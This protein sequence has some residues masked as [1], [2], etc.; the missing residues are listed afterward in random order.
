VT[1]RAVK[2]KRRA[3]A[4]L[5]KFAELIPFHDPPPLLLTLVSSAHAT[6][7]VT[8]TPLRMRMCLLLLTDK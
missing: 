7:V 5:A 1:K 4:M 2:T 3:A 6:L 8:S